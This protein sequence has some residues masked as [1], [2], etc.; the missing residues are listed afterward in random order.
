MTLAQAV[1]Q[2][3]IVF[4]VTFTAIQA[5]RL[6]WSWWRDRRDRREL[7]EA[8]EELEAMTA[9][10]GT[11]YSQMVELMHART[12]NMNIRSVVLQQPFDPSQIPDDA[13]SVRWESCHLFSPYA[14]R[15]ERTVF[16]LHVSEPPLA[17]TCVEC[18]LRQP[19]LHHGVRR[20]TYCGTLMMVHG[21]RVYVWRDQAVEVAEWRA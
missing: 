12:A 18:D 15:P 5:A 16:G 4:A 2:F 14:K 7:R 19:V 20:C 6:A 3:A 17:M 10:R 9:K 8:E 1:L 13:K 21:T 11:A